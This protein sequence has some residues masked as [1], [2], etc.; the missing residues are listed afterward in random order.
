MKRESRPD[1]MQG[2]GNRQQKAHAFL[3]EEMDNNEDLLADEEPDLGDAETDYYA[4]PE[5]DY[6]EPVCL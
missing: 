1:Q 6:Y 5:L 3:Q 2:A 4:S